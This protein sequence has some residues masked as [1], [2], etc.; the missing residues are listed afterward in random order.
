MQPWEIWTCN[1][2]DAGPH[3]AVLFTH[4]RL[5]DR[6]DVEYVNV[7]FC[8]TLRA[9]MKREPR[10][11]QVILDR[12]D[13][14]DWQTLCYCHLLHLVPKTS[15]HERRGSVSRERQ[16][17]I[18]RELLRLLPFEWGWVFKMM[19]KTTGGGQ[20]HPNLL[21]QFCKLP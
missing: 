21:R 17:Q 20:C 6:V 5:L 2:A 12:A 9:P 10:A 16:R 14:L 19:P 4:P 3:P 11:G 13:G 15:L 8:R 1:F 18:S 7:L